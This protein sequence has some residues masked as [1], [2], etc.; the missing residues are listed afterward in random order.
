[1]NRGPSHRRSA[2]ASVRVRALAGLLVLAV[3]LAAGGGGVLAQQPPEE[4]PLKP[5]DTSSPQATYLSFIGQVEELEDLLRAY[6]ADRSEARQAAFTAALTKSEALFDFSEVPDANRGEVAVASVLD[7]ADILNRLPPPEID[8]IPDAE[9]VEDAEQPGEVTFPGSEVAIPTAAEGISSY[10]L[11]GTDITIAR[12]EDGASAGDY[13]F[14]A[15]TVASLPRWRDL[16]DDLPVNDGVE[17]T[18][19]VEEEAEFTGHLVPR[20]VVDALPGSLD[21]SVLDTPLWKIVV[22]VLI[23]VLIAVAVVAWYRRVASRPVSGTSRTYLLQ[24]TTPALS[25]LLVTWARRFMNEQVNHSGDA[26]TIVNLIITFSIWAALSWGFWLATK[27]VVESVIATPRIS[28]ESVDAHLLRLL[29]KV[30][31]LGGSFALAWIG[32]S[33]LGVPTLGLGIGAGV[34]GLA[35]ALAATST[36]ENLL[37][38][39]TVYLDKPFLV[40]DMIDIDGDFGTVEAIG[41]RSTHLAGGVEQLWDHG[42]VGTQHGRPP[43]AHRF[44]DDAGGTVTLGLPRVLADTFAADHIE[45]CFG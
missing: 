24:M 10:T 42:T 45:A 44:G 11:P 33:R 20:R 12:V 22:D 4:N 32:L 40:G 8:D 9:A 38:G 18:D 30:V 21:R 28:D 14:S 26:A 43:F 19:W 29:G 35:V 25:I 15:D 27:L 36:L 41:P 16:V 7:L 23:L 17:V 13:V 2:G 34:I 6:E 5:L 31:G 37:G 1:M 3:A 39:I